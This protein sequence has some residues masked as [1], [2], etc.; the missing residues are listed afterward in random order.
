MLNSEKREYR[1]ENRLCRVTRPI[2]TYPSPCTPAI[3]CLQIILALR[4]EHIHHLTAFE[5]F[6]RM[7]RATRYGIAV[8]C[9]EQHV[10]GYVAMARHRSWRVAFDISSTAT[11]T[12][13]PVSVSLSQAALPRAERTKT[14]RRLSALSA[15]SFTNLGISVHLLRERCD[16]Y[17]NRTENGAVSESLRLETVCGSMIGP[18]L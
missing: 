10:D 13:S 17:R 4:S 11:A 16:E 14:V 3:G 1:N 5:H 18:G 6:K 8:A 2:S 15:I 9:M 7:W 12:S